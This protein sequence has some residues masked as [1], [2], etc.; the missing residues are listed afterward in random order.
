MCGRFTLAIDVEDLLYRFPMDLGDLAYKPRFNIAP[1]QEVLTYGAQGL[2]TV[3]YMRWGLIPIWKKPEQKLPLMINA[4]DDKVATSGMF[5]R[6]LQRQ[7]CLVLADSFY[8]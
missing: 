2:H 7:R 4:R 5:K 8:E 6:P 3:E 1:T